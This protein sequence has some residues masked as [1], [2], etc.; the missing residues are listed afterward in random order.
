LALR[1]ACYFGTSA[2]FWMGLQADYDL[3]TSARELKAILRRIHPNRAPR[4]RC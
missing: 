3:K 1:L 2:E 4:W